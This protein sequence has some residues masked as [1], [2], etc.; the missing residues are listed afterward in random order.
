LDQTLIPISGQ[1]KILNYNFPW[2]NKGKKL[3]TIIETWQ[4]YFLAQIQVQE[5]ENEKHII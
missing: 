4:I 5:K 1:E 2:K 3:L